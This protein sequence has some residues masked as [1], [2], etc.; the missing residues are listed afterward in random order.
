MEVTNPKGPT[1]DSELVHFLLVRSRKASLT[2]FGPHE[3][4]RELVLDLL[5]SKSRQPLQIMTQP[6]F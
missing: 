6:L 3:G 5:K 4:T 1:R 2:L